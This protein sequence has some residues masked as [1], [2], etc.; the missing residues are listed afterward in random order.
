LLDA[1][2]LGLWHLSSG[3]WAVCERH[4]GLWACRPAV[5]RTGEVGFATVTGF[6]GEMGY[7][8]YTHEPYPITGDPR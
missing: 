5:W 3:K 7:C 4:S 8:P 6:T 1:N 2:P